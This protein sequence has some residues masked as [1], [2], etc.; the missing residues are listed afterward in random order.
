MLVLIIYSECTGGS[1]CTVV[2]FV[3]PKGN[4][5]ILSPLASTFCRVL[6]H[7]G[8]ITT[9]Y[10]NITMHKNMHT[11]NIAYGCRVRQLHLLFLLDFTF[12]PIKY[13]MSIHSIAS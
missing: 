5:Q 11:P 9:K 1:E 8:T 12:K 6:P 2:T 4:Q 3:D 13:Y 7:K 10:T